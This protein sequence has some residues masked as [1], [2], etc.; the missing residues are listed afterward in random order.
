MEN[1]GACFSRN[2]LLRTIQM[3][4]ILLSQKINFLT[5]LIS[6]VPIYK[7]DKSSLG[8]GFPLWAIITLVVGSTAVLILAV[9]LNRK[10]TLIKYHYYA[11]F[12]NDDDSQDLSLMKYDVFISHRSSLQCERKLSR[13]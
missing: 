8:C 13:F 1:L 2:Y 4:K 7:L 12:T 5:L 9:V 6:D 10:W 11:R 3:L